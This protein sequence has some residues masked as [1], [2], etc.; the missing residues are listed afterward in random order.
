[1]RLSIWAANQ[2][3][4]NEKGPVERPALFFWAKHGWFLWRFGSRLCAAV[5][6]LAADQPRTE[7]EKGQS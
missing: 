7:S 1:V 2:P 3:K 5:I 6:D 4:L